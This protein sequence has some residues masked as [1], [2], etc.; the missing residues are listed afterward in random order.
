MGLH[1]VIIQYSSAVYR[2]HEGL[3]FV[4]PQYIASKTFTL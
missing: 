2:D 3:G 4:A 1:R